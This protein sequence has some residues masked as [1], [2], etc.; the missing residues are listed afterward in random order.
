[1]TE[2]DEILKAHAEERRRLAAAIHD[3]PV[4]VMAAVALRIGLLRRTLTDPAQIEA[5]EELEALVADST[6]ALRRLIA[7]LDPGVGS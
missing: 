7:E 3:D 6:A 5:C 2:R 4:Q 1:M